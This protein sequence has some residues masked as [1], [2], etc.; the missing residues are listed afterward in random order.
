MKIT[1]IFVKYVYR[2]DRNTDCNG[3]YKH[4]LDDNSKTSI[5]F[6]TTI[7]SVFLDDNN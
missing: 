5:V 1:F 3:Y 7:S 2:E 6:K 4:W